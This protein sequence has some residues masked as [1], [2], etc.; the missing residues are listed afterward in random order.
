MV[1]EDYITAGGPMS[2][3]MATQVSAANLCIP[4]GVSDSPARRERT[5]VVEVRKKRTFVNRDPAAAPGKM[6]EGQNPSSLPAIDKRP[7][8]LDRSPGSHDPG[9]LQRSASNAAASGVGSP[10]TASP[11]YAGGAVKVPEAEGIRIL[12]LREVMR[13]TGMSRSSTYAA[14]ADGKFPKQVQL[15][16]RCV[17]WRANEIDKWLRS[18]QEAH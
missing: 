1:T 8:S 15:T 10:S 9:V 14:I 18:R 16:R 7:H 5:I 4:R 3:A 6:M 17:G 13:L 11:P 2:V 12:R